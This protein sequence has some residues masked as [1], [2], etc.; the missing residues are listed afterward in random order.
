MLRH[1]II[2]P[3]PCIFKILEYRLFL[4]FVYVGKQEIGLVSDPDEDMTILDT[5]KNIAY[6]HICQVISCANYSII[7]L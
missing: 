3:D 1:L 5:T 4:E 7:Y 2:G 6:M